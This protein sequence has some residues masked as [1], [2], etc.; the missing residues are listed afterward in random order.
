MVMQCEKI[1][2]EVVELSYNSLILES[3]EY[4]I[5]IFESGM[6]LTGKLYATA[7]QIVV[8]V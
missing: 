5:F 2:C 7:L 8:N 4:F 1:C 3:T 6:A